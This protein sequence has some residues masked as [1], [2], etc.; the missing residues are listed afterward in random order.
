MQ[1]ENHETHNSL[2]IPLEINEYNENLRIP[3]ENYEN[4]A[5]TRN[6]LRINQINKN[7]KFQKRILKTMITIDFLRKNNENHENLTISC[8]LNENN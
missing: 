3:C 1:R 2:R 5:N 4:H 6:P 7:N 8:K